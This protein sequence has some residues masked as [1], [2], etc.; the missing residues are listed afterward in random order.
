MIYLDNAATSFPKPKSVI[1]ETV[2]CIKKYCANSG[3]SSHRLA[4]K[5][6]EEI[7]KTREAVSDFLSLGIPENI[8]FTT[9]ATYALN[10]A[11]K[12]LITSSC[13]ILTPIIEPI[14]DE[15]EPNPPWVFSLELLFWFELLFFDASPIM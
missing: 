3:R 2:N 8:C 1:S 14:I 4:M 9:N 5:T 13:H 6:S 10:I 15:F 7:Y 11:I 12:T